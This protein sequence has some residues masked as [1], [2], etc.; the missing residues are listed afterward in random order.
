MTSEGKMV[1][2]RIALCVAA[3][4]LAGVL[5]NEGQ[6]SLALAQPSPEAAVFLDRAVV[7]YG[8]K[9]FDDALKEL[10]EVLR[11][12]PQSVDAL[13]YQGL[14]YL[15]L[16]R[17]ADAR[18]ALEKARGI[19]PAD[20]DVA[21]QLGVVYFNQEEY[22]KAEPLLRQSYQADPRR[23]N[24]GYY[25]GFIQFRKKNYREALTLL[26]ANVPSDDNFAQ[27]TRFYSGLALSALGFP[28]EAE[29]QIQEALRLQ[30]VSPIVAPAQR[31]GEMLESA[32]KRER[33][34]H[35]E[36][37]LGVF[38]DTNV[39][40]VP[41]A[42][43]D[44][45]GQ[46][47]REEHKREK[48]EGELASLD[49]S[50]T[51]L[52]TPD[53]EGTI[54]HRF[55]QTYN[56]HLTQFN[57]QSNTPTLGISYRGSIGQKPEE[58][59]NYFTGLQY[60]Y[61][62]ITLGNTRFTQ[63]W[64]VNPYF[65]LVENPSNLTTLVFRFQVKDFFNDEKVAREEVRDALNYMAGPLHFFL[66]GEG[67]HYIKLGYQFDFDDAKGQNWTYLGNRLLAGA[68]YTLPWWDVRLRYDLDFHWRSY[69]YKN[70]LL[71]VTALNTIKRRDQEPVQLISVAKDFS[72][73]SSKSFPFVGCDPH[74]SCPFTVSLDYLFDNNDSNLSPYAYKRHVVTTSFT[75]RF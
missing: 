71:P 69:K 5:L 41:N 29:A 38:Y 61:D 12:D 9:R 57:T 68:Q 31:F 15:A 43:S 58:A 67:R 35:G 33:F 52:K 47:L 62:F 14:V 36:L 72:T 26:R 27:L 51:W 20:I 16:N 70:S 21:F 59:W 4:L 55:F 13:Y 2:K 39:P 25:L 63:R 22:E 66:F 1:C 42:S 19:R 48:S 6:F 8:E 34:F 37:R 18:A 28:R 10:E 7:A 11:P 73:D 23:P 56:N 54:S 40:V 53:W 17:P 60:T 50:Y 44:I 49:L 3:L 24:V 75:W 64:I 74:G 32:A 45:V 65:T 46:V 30:P